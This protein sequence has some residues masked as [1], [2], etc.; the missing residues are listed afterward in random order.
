VYKRNSSVM[1]KL[2]NHPQ[3]VVAEMMEGF[4]V[5]HQGLALLSDHHVL[6]RADAEEVRDRQVA[7]ISGGGSGHEPAHAGYIGAGMLSAAVAG[8]VFA[9]PSPDS[10]FAAIQAVGGKPGVLLI[11]KNYTGDRLNFGLA[12][13]M[14]RGEGI[15]VETVVVA[16]DI[17]LVSTKQHAG[18]RGIA[19][20]VLVHKVAGAAASEGKS[21][22]EVAAVARATAD[23]VASM[24]VALSAGTVPSVGKPSFVLGQEEVE[25][26]LGIH[27]EPG[28][29]RVR[30]PP[31]N[32]L[33]NELIEAIVSAQQL[34]KDNRIAVLVNNLGSTTMMELAIFARGALSSLESRDLFIE[35]VY[36]GTFMTSLEAAGV[37]LSI[38][39][40]DDDRL[41]RLDAPTSAP[42]WPNSAVKHL[43]R[44]RD[45]LIPS[46]QFIPV[47][48]R[49]WSDQPPNKMQR[50][51]RAACRALRDAELRLTDLDQAVGDGDLGVSLARGARAVEESL[52]M[53]QLDNPAE[54]LKS[55]G[56]TLQKVVGG[57][58]GPFYAVSL[59]R[60]ANSL[61]LGNTD[62]PKAWA[63]ASLDACDAISEL[64]GAT[65]GDRTMLDAL[66][67]F[68]N[69]LATGLEQGLSTA[70]ALEAA[71]SAAEAGAEATARM[72]PQ[73]GR[74]SYLGDRA[75]GHPDP[76]AVAVAV[77]L[78]AAANALSTA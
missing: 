49:D 8:E 61:R 26:G 7:L 12:A 76:G 10:V 1:K 58:S 38:L 42:A 20:T 60:A 63:K 75:I 34:K 33:A 54:A 64:G 21:L 6:L 55:T 46:R 70:Q 67:P 2:I 37:S 71:V 19:G 40:V 16:D 66:I 14:A 18:A 4:L 41:R 47:P 25:L 69:A 53:Y 23:A 24:G 32:E 51:I 44:V 50:A 68:A 3:H 13:E 45:R 78:R 31:A 35:R 17:A 72:I 29:R 57:S 27:G 77:W 22:E 62:D 65:A 11:V 74:S 28:I 59:L 30:L 36:A 5:M 43:G 39:R 9:S 48:Y 56:L 73:R 15:A 52:P